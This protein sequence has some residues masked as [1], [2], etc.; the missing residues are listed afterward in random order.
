[1]DEQ[2]NVYRQFRGAALPTHIL[3]DG[4]GIVRDIV[5]G[6]L[7]KEQLQAKISDLIK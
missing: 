3:I 7:P 4:N 2:A 1:M 6:A 5:I